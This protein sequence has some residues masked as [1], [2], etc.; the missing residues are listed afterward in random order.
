MAMQPTRR[1][2]TWVLIAVTL[3]L[4]LVIGGAVLVGSGVIKLPVIVDP[5]ASPS[6]A[7]SSSAQASTA[8]STSP[9]APLP[10]SWTA[11]GEMI[12]SRQMH[13]A[14]RLLD[15]RVLVAGGVTGID[16]QELASA[17]VFDPSTGTW[18]ATGS[19]TEARYLHNATL[20]PS[21]MVLVVGGATNSG[22]AEL[23][24][25]SSEAWTPAGSMIQGRNEFS[26]T[27]LPNG[28]VLVAG[29]LVTFGGGD[30]TVFDS[31]E[32]YDPATGSWAAT[33]SMVSPRQGHSA[34]LLPNGF[35]LVA[36]G[37]TGTDSAELYDP[38]SGKWI[39]TGN[40]VEARASV[41]PQHCCPTGWCSSPAVAMPSAVMSRALPSCMTRSTGLG[42]P[43]RAC[44]RP[45][46]CLPWAV[47]PRCWPM[48]G[49]YF[50]VASSAAAA[51]PS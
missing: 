42:P 49:C 1:S 9:V 19:M 26:A 25:P 46:S 3:L 37:S 16:N 17:E 30:I 15:G 39:A 38:N 8:A 21:G 35:V 18:T 28:K 7:P 31:A 33:G 23:Y 44:P 12:G 4:A 13:T 48:A 2:G 50:P 36:G 51:T 32:L 45:I 14:T 11:T 24:D 43:R 40:M 6:S 41:T 10:A 5:S 34:T 27:L 20:L 29:G 22:S 47:R